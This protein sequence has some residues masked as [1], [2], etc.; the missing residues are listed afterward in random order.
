[1]GRILCLCV[2]LTAA[3]APFQPAGSTQILP[4][5]LLVRVRDQDY[6]WEHMAGVV[7]DYFR[8]EREERVKQQGDAVTEGTLETYYEVGATLLEPWRSDSAG[9]YNRVESTLQTIRRKA[10]VKV[11]PAPEGYLV[12]VSVFKELEDLPRPASGAA[13]DAIFRYDTGIDRFTDPVG[14]T[15]RTRGWIPQGRDAELEQRILARILSCT[16]P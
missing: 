6:V 8:I 14:P 7:G 2:L 15:P 3:C 9:V 12:E 1:M 11:T 16:Q 5:P 10:V 4:N 13:A